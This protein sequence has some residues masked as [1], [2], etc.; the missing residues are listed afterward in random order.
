MRFGARVEVKDLDGGDEE[1]FELVG[2]G[3]EDYSK[4]KILI[5]SPIGQGLVGKK[6]GDVVEIQVPMGKL[7]FEILTISYP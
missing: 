3:D 5:T 1:A 4:N 7:H 2:P 6:P